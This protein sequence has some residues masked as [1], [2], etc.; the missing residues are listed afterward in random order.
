MTEIQVEI[1]I[2]RLDQI[3]YFIGNAYTLMIVI[4]SVLILRFLLWK[5]L[6]QYA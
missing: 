5:L 1:L 3:T 2:Q 6:F 4:V